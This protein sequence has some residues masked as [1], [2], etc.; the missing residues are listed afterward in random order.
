MR[1]TPIPRQQ[2]PP[3]QQ[4]Q[5]QIRGAVDIVYLLLNGSVRGQRGDEQY[6]KIWSDLL[7]S[8]GGNNA[9]ASANANASVN[10]DALNKDDFEVMSD[11]GVGVVEVELV[12]EDATDNTDTA[13]G[14]AV[15]NV[16]SDSIGKIMSWLPFFGRMVEAAK[17]DPDGPRVVGEMRQLGQSV[18]ARQGGRSGLNSVLALMSALE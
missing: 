9:N 1:T 11:D 7:S 15:L 10:V 13:I 17:N 16:A 6:H 3:K 4:Q 8:G 12:G 2:Q 14:A 18:I 5:Q